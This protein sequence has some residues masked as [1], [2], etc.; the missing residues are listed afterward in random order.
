M[1]AS[2]QLLNS[3]QAQTDASGGC[4]PGTIP[5]YTATGQLYVNGPLL[6]GTAGN[7]LGATKQL[8]LTSFRNNDGTIPAT[9]ATTAAT[10]SFGLAN[11]TGTS[12]QLIT[13]GANGVT[14]TDIAIVETTMPDFFVS[15]AAFNVVVN[16]NSVANSGS[17]STQTVGVNV[18]DLAMSGTATAVLTGTSVTVGSAA[19]SYTFAVAGANV[20]NATDRLMLQLTAIITEN[21]TAG[22]STIGINSVALVTL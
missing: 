22:A 17:I 6:I 3:G 11:T 19:A 15:G 18:Y 10:G 2:A 21:K 9:T 20:V 1:A 7:A 5:V 14:K 8:T 4:T 16:A 12:L 13:A